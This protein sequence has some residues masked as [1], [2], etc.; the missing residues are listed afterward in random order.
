MSTAR[1]DKSKVTAQG[2]VPELYIDGVK[3]APLFYSLS[4]CPFGRAYTAV[5]QK[6]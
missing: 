2:G 6:T 3:T 5:S 1:I 4:D